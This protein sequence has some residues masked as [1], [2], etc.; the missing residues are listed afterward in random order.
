MRVPVAVAGKMGVRELEPE[1]YDSFTYELFS[2]CQKLS[3]RI[4]RWA[5]DPATDKK[6]PFDLNLVEA[7]RI[8]HL[9]GRSAGGNW[10]VLAILLDTWAQWNQ[11]TSAT[12]IIKALGLRGSNIPALVS[13]SFLSQW[14]KFN[15]PCVRLDERSACVLALTRGPD[16]DPEDEKASWDAFSI[17]LPPGLVPSDQG[18]GKFYTR[19]ELHR[20]KD[21]TYCWYVS[22]FDNGTHVDQRTCSKLSELVDSPEWQWTNNE[23]PE[24]PGAGTFDDLVRF[25]QENTKKP[26]KVEMASML[27]L[28]RIVL[29]T[30]LFMSISGA[31]L[32]KKRRSNKAAGGWRRRLLDPQTTDYVLTPPVTVDFDLLAA[33]REIQQ[34]CEGGTT[35]RALSVLQWIVR[36]HWRHQACGPQLSERKWTWV[37]PYW[38]GPETGKRSIHEHLV[39]EKGAP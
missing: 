12:N 30:V 32:P 23:I 34:A 31:V 29:S 10:A 6:K 22:F 5:S 36:G 27:V 39:R 33:A 28:G 38:K 2:A 13:A 15:C 16:L 1:E 24:D 4:F 17:G 18:P 21:P 9:V 8:L 37:A 19:I 11:E 20:M 14:F 3:D 35:E 7:A 25:A 26:K